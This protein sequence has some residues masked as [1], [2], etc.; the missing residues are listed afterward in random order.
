MGGYFHQNY[1]H[2]TV[3]YSIYSYCIYLY[4][5]CIFLVNN[6]NNKQE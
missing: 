4:T 3:I 5:N 1:Y 2:V 6:N